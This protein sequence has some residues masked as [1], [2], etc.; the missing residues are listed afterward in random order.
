MTIFDQLGRA[1]TN[2]SIPEP[3]PGRDAYLDRPAQPDRPAYLDGLEKSKAEV[4]QSITACSPDWAKRTTRTTWTISRQNTKR[5]CPLSVKHSRKSPGASRRRMKLPLGGAV[6]P[7]GRSCRRGPC[8]ATSAGR[9]SRQLPAAQ[10]SRRQSRGC[11][12]SARLRSVRTTYSVSRVEWICVVRP[13]T[14]VCD[15]ALSE[16]GETRAQARGKAQK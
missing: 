15:G 6:R 9:S 1:V 14:E 8:S 13:Q 16:S 2:S 5:R 4:T 11:A 12:P 7:V 3:G 10:S